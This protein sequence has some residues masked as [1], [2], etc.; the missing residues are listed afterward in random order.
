[1]NP[2]ARRFGTPIRGEESTQPLKHVIADYRH[3]AQAVTCV[4]GWQGSS[5]TTD[6]R[7]SAW[8][9]HVA[10]NRPAKP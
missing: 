6:G 1:M 2:P 7:T 3:R 5:A 4:C 10:E 9:I 8:S